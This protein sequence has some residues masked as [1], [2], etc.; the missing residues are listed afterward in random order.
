MRG[1]GRRVSRPALLVGSILAASLVGCDA[2]APN[3][4]SSIPAR[5]SA[6]LAGPPP[7]ADVPTFRGSFART[8]QMPGPGPGRDAKPVQ[9]W[10]HISA[11]GYDAQPLIV[12][13]EV[14]VI[15]VDGE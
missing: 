4:S 8:G 15:S 3:P 10:E 2:I 6:G 9:L 13:G 7:F 11:A 12:D 1:Q 5:P 14:I